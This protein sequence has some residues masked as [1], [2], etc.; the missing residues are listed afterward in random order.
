MGEKRALAI[1][2]NGG[3]IYVIGRA[4]SRIRDKTEVS[5][6]HVGG[7]QVITKRTINID[8]II[9]IIP[10]PFDEKEQ[11]DWPVLDR[12]VD[13]ACGID[14]CAV[15]LPAYASEFYK[16]SDEERRQIIARAVEHASHRVPVIAQANAGSAIH[17]AGLARFAQD[18]GAAAV[19]VAV[20]RQFAVAE[21]DLLRYFDRILSAI[22]VPLVL[23]DF[24]PGGSTV[25]VSFITELHRLHPHFR[26]VKLEEA[27]M[28]ARVRS[29]L[30]A[31]SGEVGVLEGWGGMY[32]LEL[33]PAGICGVMPSLSLADLL[34]RIYR[35]AQS[36]HQQEAYDVFARTLPQIV[37]SLQNLELYHHA[38][39]RLLVARGI[40]RQS[41]VRDLRIELTALD[42]DHIDFLNANVL[43]LLDS[44]KMPR[45]PL[46]HEGLEPGRQR[47]ESEASGPAAGSRSTHS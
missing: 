26:W 13:F 15:C 36:G 12:L 7:S 40:I 3:K 43:A 30:D 16:L 27:L 18:A 29:I 6:R 31:S 22:D 28:A 17:A 5:G 1:A 47:F 39:K 19:A 14:V 9:P 44:L 37:F 8:G 41:F 4:G 25:S 21:R 46:S 10:T 24:N 35:L 34:A 33:V 42:A 32:L 2:I 20:P 38:E 11:I 23:Q 45:C